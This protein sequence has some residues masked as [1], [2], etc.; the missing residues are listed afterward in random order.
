M[1]LA[2][3]TIDLDARTAKLEE[4][5]HKAEQAS[6][7][8]AKAIEHSFESVRQTLDFAA[9]VIGLD[10]TIEGFKELARVSLEAMEGLNHT[11]AATG[12]SIENL[13]AL[14]N[15]ARRNGG[16][17]ETVTDV[18]V[19]FNLALNKPEAEGS[20][21]SRALKA[22]GLDAVELRK[23]DP[24]EALQ[25][26]AQALAG[27]EDGGNKARLVQE[28]FG[29][30]IREA[31]PFLKQLAE[32]GKLNATV[33]TQQ[34]E[35]AE[36]FAQELHT[37]A[38]NSSLFARSL[39]SDAIP[40]LNAWIEREIAAKE[41]GFGMFDSERFRV[42]TDSIFSRNA[43][44]QL[45]KYSA[46]LVDVEK[47]LTTL[48]SSN[49]PQGRRRKAWDDEAEKLR[50]LVKYYDELIR[51]DVDYS[52]EGKNAPKLAVPDFLTP[53]R[54][55]EFTGA[56]RDA[57]EYYKA[58]FLR[59]E[60][61][62]YTAKLPTDTSLV[63]PEIDLEELKQRND[64][65][66]EL[67]SILASTPTKQLEQLVDLENA[68]ND[69]FRFGQI[70]PEEYAQAL[71]VLATKFDKTGD[72]LARFAEIGRERIQSALG[73]SLFDV[74]NGKFNNIGTAF[75]NLIK[76]MV[77]ESLAA[78]IMGKLFPKSGSSDSSSLLTGFL[79]LFGGNRATGGPV[80]AGRMYEVNEGGRPEVFGYQ[81]RQ[82]LLNGK[83]DGYVRPLG[84]GGGGAGG[85]AR[86]DLSVTIGSVGEGVS[87]AQVAS[88]VT[89]AQRAQESRLMRLN[90]EG[91]F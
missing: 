80:Q 64:L 31:G 7:R 62:I 26:V 68:L 3:L 59:S 79:A 87:M 32:A 35:E 11:K 30:S 52:H 78:D 63:G 71:D 24:A 47:K 55:R 17:L 8:T 19:K 5:F 50:K 66:R 74:L 67:N 2:T 23:I 54:K 60:K 65:A 37:L 83:N 29:K 77:A 44:D 46:A 84:Q 56:I 70:G 25:K 89:Q 85:G 72:D 69:A 10:L 39:L 15:I 27:Y 21:T 20:A 6:E 82:Y 13:S 48:N 34:A 57:K 16:T 33:T 88:V 91:R 45:D 73:D 12:A 42:A 76:R 41:A 43:R 53:E 75:G 22:I 4:S 14:E 81:G 51:L 61:D 9:G 38:T 1:P 49:D 36:K 58:E 86:Y 90:R 18:L 28:L 40:A